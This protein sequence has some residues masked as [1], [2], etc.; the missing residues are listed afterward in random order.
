M[1]EKRL[2]YLLPEDGPD[3]PAG[4]LHRPDVGEPAPV[5][6]GSKVE[7]E[8]E[9]QSA[10]M[11]LA[12]LRRLAAKLE[13]EK[14]LTIPE[15]IAKMEANLKILEDSGNFSKDVLYQMKAT[16]AVAKKNPKSDIRFLEGEIDKQIRMH[17][18]VNP[19]LDSQ[20]TGKGELDHLLDGSKVTPEQEAEIFAALEKAH[21]TPAN[22]KPLDLSKW[23]IPGESA[24]KAEPGDEA[25]ADMLAE[26]E[27]LKENPTDQI[28][29]MVEA[30][31]FSLKAYRKSHKEMM[32]QLTNMESNLKD[33]SVK[34]PEIEKA[35]ASLAKL[36]TTI[37]VMEGEN[38]LIRGQ[39]HSAT[40]ESVPLLEDQSNDMS[41]RLAALTQEIDSVQEEV[42]VAI[43][44]ANEAISEYKRAEAEK[45]EQD[46]ALTKG[47][48]PAPVAE[49]EPN[50]KPGEFAAKVGDLRD[51]TALSDISAEDVKTLTAGQKAA[52]E[53][54]KQA[55]QDAGRF[56]NEFYSALSERRVINSS[57]SDLKRL[58]TVLSA[59]TFEQ[60]KGL[61]QPL[62]PKADRVEITTDN[63][64]KLYPVVVDQLLTDIEKRSGQ[65]RFG[66]S[67][68]ERARSL[69]YAIIPDA[70]KRAGLLPG[71]VAT[72]SDI[73]ARLRAIDQATPLAVAKAKRRIAD[74]DE[75]RKHE[76]NTATGSLEITEASED[77][78]RAELAKEHK[79]EPSQMSELAT[80]RHGFTRWGSF[81]EK[82]MQPLFG[83]DALIEAEE[84]NG[85]LPYFM[86]FKRAYEGLD[87]MILTPELKATTKENLIAAVKA[88]LLEPSLAVK[89]SYLET[90]S[91]FL[92]ETVS[93]NRALAGLRKDGVIDAQKFAELSKQLTEGKLAEVSFEVREYLAVKTLASQ[94]AKSTGKAPKD[95]YQENSSSL[96]LQMAKLQDSQTV[97]K[98][99]DRIVGGLKDELKELRD[100]GYLD[101]T[102]YAK[103]TENATIEDV[104]TLKQLIE[105]HSEA[106]KYF[107][108]NETE[109]AINSGFM[110]IDPKTMT[111]DQYKAAVEAYKLKEKAP[112]FKKEDTLPAVAAAKL[113][114]PPVGKPVADI[115]YSDVPD[116][117]LGIG[118]IETVGGSDYAATAEPARD[119]DSE[120]VLTDEALAAAARE[121]YNSQPVVEAKPVPTLTAAEAA[122][123]DRLLAEVTRKSPV[124]SPAEA[125][126]PEDLH[127]FV[128]S[129]EPPKTREEAYK[130]AEAIIDEAYAKPGP[131]NFIDYVSSK[132]TTAGVIGE[133]Q[134]MTPRTEIDK[135]DVIADA[136]ALIDAKFPESGGTITFDEPISIRQAY[137][138]DGNPI[139][140]DAAA[141]AAAAPNIERNDS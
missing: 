95:F 36:F 16:L 15:R 113:P 94:L 127:A 110:G 24:Q 56:Q 67:R 42:N 57:W 83:S 2:I 50:I 64:A 51:T 78:F 96:S 63:I 45:A 11:D 132:L 114:T 68:E 81:A 134:F 133:L 39:L 7:P 28:R 108:A 53:T 25:P 1:K 37:E 18:A 119:E 66:G 105:V 65:P 98:F 32:A 19:V 141:A 125:K 121:I 85:A 5:I 82:V 69:L 75:L 13:P 62:V 139:P 46:E 107:R 99:E 84:K 33:T 77:R 104:A 124:P 123:N 91:N 112:L 129:L 6:L 130:R 34:S 29:K 87:N 14:K 44:S 93:N 116:V 22:E 23:G 120:P 8:A 3:G 128:E 135:N 70:E 102:E 38:S 61:I 80:I 122:E 17:T 74:A 71:A 117:S 92:A 10:E 59:K 90:V 31:D 88:D 118:G 48:A 89:G 115:G 27:E 106:K 72:D 40:S 136:K 47:E 12:E 35:K 76:I 109:V 86:T 43:A 137:D 73:D 79:L 97:K 9:K 54:P 21:P 111:I 49:P 131:G 52:E 26:D 20:A 58:E 138:E 126:S 101:P 140:A 41:T 30:F 4:E 100:Q 55:E 103:A 60:K